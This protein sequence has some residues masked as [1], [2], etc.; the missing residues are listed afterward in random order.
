ME[1][2]PATTPSDPGASRVIEYASPTRQRP[3]RATWL[4]VAA[5]SAAL[6]AF[7]LYGFCA[8][9]PYLIGHLGFWT[10]MK[11][12]EAVAPSM[13]G[14]ALL[15]FPFAVVAVAQ[16]EGR[17]ALAWIALALSIAFWLCAIIGVTTAS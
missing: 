6:G 3:R 11:V 12:Q 7:A 16:Q 10:M 9:L 5:L 15:D 4:E 14:V 17:K 1:R 2:R 8:L 13:L